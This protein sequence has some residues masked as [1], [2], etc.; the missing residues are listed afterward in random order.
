LV[1]EVVSGLMERT[2]DCVA[3]GFPVGLVPSGTANA[4]A[5]ELDLFQS[6]SW[7]APSVPLVLFALCLALVIVVAPLHS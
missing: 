2:D 6:D 5:N 4:M 3:S 7:V 1:S